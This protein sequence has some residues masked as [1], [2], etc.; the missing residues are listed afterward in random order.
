MGAACPVRPPEWLWGGAQLGTRADMVHGADCEGFSATGRASSACSRATRRRAPAAS[1]CSPRPR[2]R[3]RPTMR[4]HTRR[5]R[6]PAWRRPRRCWSAACCRARRGS[7]ALESKA[8]R[9]PC[10]LAWRRPT[11]CWSAAC[12]RA[13]RGSR[14]PG[15]HPPAPTGPEEAWSAARS[16][17]AAVPEG[18]AGRGL[19]EGFQ[20]S[21]CP[22][23]H[24]R[25]VAVDCGGLR[26]GRRWLSVLP[27]TEGLGTGLPWGAGHAV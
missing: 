4:A 5:P 2:T 18:R 11:R 12:C 9:C 13:R 16:L 17:P 8:S 22:S 19:R 25:R 1:Q 21:A 27:R 15:H 10:P 24:T 3:A 26:P 23:V 20:R 14:G 7:R 6:P